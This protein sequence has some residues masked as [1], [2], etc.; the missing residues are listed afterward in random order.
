MAGGALG[1]LTAGNGDE[2]ST[3]LGLMSEQPPVFYPT[4]FASPQAGTSSGY[5]NRAVSSFSAFDFTFS[6][7]RSTPVVPVAGPDQPEE[8]QELVSQLTMSPQ[9]AKSLS[10]L[11]QENVAS[12][13]ARFGSTQHGDPEP[14]ATADDD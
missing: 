5:V 12:Y 13:E 10:A 7:M 6:F 2:P 8:H 14:E 9:Y 1:Q 4:A 11:L 3:L